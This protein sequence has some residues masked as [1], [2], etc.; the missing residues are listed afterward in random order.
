MLHDVVGTVDH[1][2]TEC[3]CKQDD[4]A[5]VRS[6]CGNGQRDATAV[7]QRI[8]CKRSLE[9]HHLCFSGTRLCP[10]YRRTR[11]DRPSRVP[12]R[13]LLAPTFGGGCEWRGT[14]EPLFGKSL[15]LAAHV[16]NTY[17][18]ASRILPDGIGFLPS[19]GVSRYVFP[20]SLAGRWG[21]RPHLLPG[22]VGYFPRPNLSHPPPGRSCRPN[23]RVH[24]E[25]PEGYKSFTYKLQKTNG[26]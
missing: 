12:Q 9:S 6:G 18:K 5:T 4:V 15:P 21:Q 23:R 16:R 13:S 26:L 8:S 11:Q 1:D 25:Q 20:G 22:Q 2:L 7:H 17:I 19:P 10:P 3:H 24:G 14:T